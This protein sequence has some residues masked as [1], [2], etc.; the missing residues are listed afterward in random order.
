M[1]IE[2]SLARLRMTGIGD[3]LLFREQIER[4]RSLKRQVE[5]SLSPSSP[6]LQLSAGRDRSGDL[7]PVAR[8]AIVRVL[9]DTRG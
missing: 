3:S 5:G 6:G 2:D 9:A 7:K 8:P 1:S 4:A